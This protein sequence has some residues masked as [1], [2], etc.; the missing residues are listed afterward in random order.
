MLVYGGYGNS[1]Q[2]LDPP[3]QPSYFLDEM[4]EYSFPTDRCRHLITRGVPRPLPRSRYAMVHL[5]DDRLV[6]MG[7]MVQGDVRNGETWLYDLMGQ[8]WSPT[9]IPA[10]P[11][12]SAHS[13]VAMDATTCVAYGGSD[14]TSISG[15]TRDTMYVLQI[16]PRTS[17]KFFVAKFLVL[18]DLAFLG[19]ATSEVS[20]IGCP[21]F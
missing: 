7:G 5:G 21:A 10:L 4:L 3:S 8:Q 17:L 12:V 18:N 11:G 19:Q 2:M 20:S 15:N 9:A 13:M 14:T 1:Q 16:Q 6:V